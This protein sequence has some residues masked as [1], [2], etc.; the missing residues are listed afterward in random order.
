LG[1]LI[2]TE[3]GAI[4]IGFTG[5]NRL[6]RFKLEDLEGYLLQKKERTKKEPWKRT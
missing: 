2:F 1:Y 6:R 4:L 5:V 3:F